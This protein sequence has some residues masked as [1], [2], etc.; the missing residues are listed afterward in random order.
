MFNTLIHLWPYTTAWVMSLDKNRACAFNKIHLIDTSTFTKAI[1]ILGNYSRLHFVT[2][3]EPGSTP[4][5]DDS[6]DDRSASR[7]WRM[8]R[9]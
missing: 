9:N 3:A 8:G 5:V 4:A 7:L 2:I 6:R 1:K